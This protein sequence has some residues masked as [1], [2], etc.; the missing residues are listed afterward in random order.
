MPDINSS[1]S[2]PLQGGRCDGLLHISASPVRV[3]RV[4]PP[5]LGAL[6]L[7]IAG[8][9]IV[10]PLRA[11]L[12]GEGLWIPALGGPDHMPVVAIGAIFAL[13]GLDHLIGRQ[14][15]VIAGGIVRVL[16]RRVNGVRRWHEPLANYLGLHHRRQRVHHRYGW[17]IVHRLELAHPEPAKKLCLMSTRDGRRLEACG[18]QWAAQLG[19]PV[20]SAESAARDLAPGAI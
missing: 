3:E 13:W 1:F 11:L 15:I 20:L 16:T 17:R 14:E 2:A 8:V 6:L 19:M 10:A 7:A 5:M 9:W 12:A 4:G 18:R